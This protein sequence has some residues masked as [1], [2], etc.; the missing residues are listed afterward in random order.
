MN[1][2]VTYDDV[3][4]LVWNIFGTEETVYAKTHRFV[5]ASQ[6][7]EENE[8]AFLLWVEKLSRCLNLFN[9]DNARQQFACVVGV[10]DLEKSFFANSAHGNKWVDISV[11][12]MHWT[13][14][15]HNYLITVIAVLTLNCHISASSVIIMCNS[16]VRFSGYITFSEHFTVTNYEMISYNIHDIK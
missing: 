9:N 13:E 10:N 1:A 5:T 7:A 12:S 8:T 14:L 3:M 6:T 16:M 4:T 11:M 2:N 15:S